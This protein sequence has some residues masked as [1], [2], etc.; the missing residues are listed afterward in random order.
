M[1][2]TTEAVLKFL[3]VQG[4]LVAALIH[5][6]IGLPLLFVY[7]PLGS[8]ADPRPYL[9][10]PSALLLL[11]VLVGIY[12]DRAVR[13]LYALGALIL[14]GYA[15]GYAWWHLTDHGGLLP[16]HPEG[17]PVALVIEHLFEDAVA[18]V[19]KVAELVGAGAFIAL[20]VGG[21]SESDAASGSDSASNSGSPSDSAPN[22]ERDAESP[23]E[24]T[25]DAN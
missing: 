21:G 22:S 25:T 19:S 1:D 23:P 17:S 10:V 11:V 7:L 12:L 2:D 20:L 4:T 16:A 9:F 14:L 24:S 6:W 18:F 3:G 8:F 13:P 5:L 15:A